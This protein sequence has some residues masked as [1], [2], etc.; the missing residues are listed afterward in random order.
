M[1]PRERLCE[2]GDVSDH[3]ER[4]RTGVVQPNRA[5]KR[6]RGL[7]GTG[8]LSTL[9]THPDHRFL[10]DDVSMGDSDVPSIAGYRQV[11]DAH[12]LTLARRRGVRLVTF[13]SSILAMGDGN[14]VEVLTTL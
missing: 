6:D 14:G 3:R 2:M 10:T 5:A 13:D 8:V 11:T 4:L 9:R 12:L 7:C 1:V